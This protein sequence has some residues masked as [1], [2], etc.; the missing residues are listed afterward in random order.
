M[1]FMYLTLK[2]RGSLRCDSVIVIPVTIIP[3]NI[4]RYM[5]LEIQI[6]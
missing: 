5:P 1:C 2:T 3:D 6:F 4:R